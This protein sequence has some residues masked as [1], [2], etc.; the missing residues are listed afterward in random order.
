M[1]L[2][3]LPISTAKTDVTLGFPS[4]SRKHDPGINRFCPS[5]QSPSE[6]VAEITTGALIPRS[7]EQVSVSVKGPKT[8]S[9]PAPTVLVSVI[10]VT[11]PQQASGKAVPGVDA[12]AGIVAWKKSR[13]ITVMFFS[14]IVR[15]D[16]PSPFV[17]QP[18]VTEVGVNSQPMKSR[19]TSH[20][21]FMI[22]TVDRSGTA[23]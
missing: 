12:S 1:T 7:M 14:G 21:A 16:T 11:P 4:A 23:G 19:V 9:S 22:P 5:A 8:L 17:S 13:L 20:S 15:S 6:G 3:G 18:S 2:L 10:L